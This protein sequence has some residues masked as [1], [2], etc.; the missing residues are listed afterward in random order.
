MGAYRILSLLG[1]GGMGEVYLGEDVTLRRK[2]AIKLLPA[3]FTS[4]AV[5]VMR[6]VQ[7]AR[8]AS[9]L[10][11]PNI[12]TINAIGEAPT[13][14]GVMRY[15]VN[16]YI[17][18]ETLRERMSDPSRKRMKPSEAV[19]TAAQIAAA[20][21]AAHEAGI[22]HRDIKPENVMVRRDGLVKVLDFG[23]AKLTEPAPD[24]IHS[25]ASTIARNSTEAG[26]VLGTPRYMSPEQVRG[27]KV[28]A[29]T[30]I[31]SLGVILYEMLTGRAPFSGATSN[32]V[33]AAIMRDAHQPLAE[34]SPDAPPGLERIVSRALHKDRD[35]RYQTVRELQQELKE[36]TTNQAFEARLERAAEPPERPAAVQTGSTYATH[37]GEA[38]KAQTTSG[39]LIDRIKSHE[40]SVGTGYRSRDCPCGHC[41][42][43]STSIS[44][45]FLTAKDTIL[46]ADFEQ[47]GDDV[48][49]ETLKQVLATKLQESPLLQVF[50]EARL[51]QTLRLMERAP[52]TRVT[53]EVAQEICERQSLKAFIVGSI[54]SLGS[55]YIITLATFQ[56]RNGEE[57]HR[58]QA[59]AASK[60]QVLNALS[61]ASTQLRAQL[62]ESLNSIQQA[63][64]PLRGDDIKFWRL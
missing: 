29:R 11:H 46:L 18:G 33:I 7:E 63:A 39:M 57:L 4:D 45:L 38:A 61:Q 17:D 55:H 51:R 31:F 42:V 24:V 9:A 54:T 21:A 19:N 37:T 56:G 16:E 23:L 52:D 44:V 1:K 2:V 47:A 60:D 6:F 28:D 34:C 12:I 58:T 8:A 15:I 13:E 59:E 5:R 3:E 36:L 25:Q 26:V 50:P 22:I 64:K 14:G 30:D 49:D 20:L 27:E 53:G 43:T 10:N 32:E 48:F 62:G 40:L 35:G 41:E